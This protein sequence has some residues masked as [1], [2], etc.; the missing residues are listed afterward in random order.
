MLNS[1]CVSSC[2]CLNIRKELI[3]VKQ[4]L[5]LR[6][7]HYVFVNK[8]SS[9]H[10]RTTS[11]ASKFPDVKIL[12]FPSSFSEDVFLESSSNFMNPKSFVNNTTQVLWMSPLIHPPRSK[13]G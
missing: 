9:E 12:Y 4:S 1:H 10:S 3:L 7:K 6:V 13:L 5:K 11:H 2:M 8:K